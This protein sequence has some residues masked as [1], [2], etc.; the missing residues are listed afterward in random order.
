MQRLLALVTA[1]WLVFCGAAMAQE[2]A[3]GFAFYSDV[4][5]NG[6]G[7]DWVGTRI[8]VMKLYD[9]SYVTLINRAN[10]DIKS[11]S[12]A[13]R[14]R[15]MEF[16]PLAPN[17]KITMTFT[18]A[19][20]DDYHVIVKFADGKRLEGEVGYVTTQLSS[21]DTIH[22]YSDKIQLENLAPLKS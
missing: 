9:T 18:D 22:L 11:V 19:G 12:V 21:T 2:P 10:K 14:N 6:Q 7:G 4:C 17:Q 5:H 1:T 3:A 8:G 20:E 13:I 15:A 16:G